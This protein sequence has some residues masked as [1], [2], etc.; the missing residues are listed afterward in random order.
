[1]ASHAQE[2]SETFAHVVETAGK[3]VVRVDGRRRA[4]SGIAYSDKLVIAADHAVQRDESVTV[5]DG[6]KEHTAKV[7][8]RD[9][10]T[11]LVLLE[12]EGGLTPAQ[13]HDGQGVKVGHWVLSLARPGETV[14]AHSGIISALGHK[15]FRA[16]R[17]G[18][19]IDRYLESDAAHAPGFSGGPLVGLDGRVLGLNTSGLLRGQSV[20]IPSATVQRVVKQLEAHGKIRRS[21]LGLTMQPLGLPEEVRKATGEEVGLMVVAVEPG[22]PSEQ[23]G[24][25]FGDTVLH[26]GDDTV[27]TVDD[28]FAYLRKDHVGEKISVRFFRQGKVDT[29]HVTLGARP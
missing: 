15:P 25:R 13:W 17:G 20:T 9:S 23:A 8:G 21:Y 22:G 2:F 5:Y 3:S 6:Q 29:V 12:I 19:E 10:S 14:R 18:G 28:V 16:G 1:M 24:L 4:A 7:R 27:K 11:D 26:L